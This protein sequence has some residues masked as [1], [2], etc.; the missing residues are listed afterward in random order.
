MHQQG[1]QDM[2]A[3]PVEAEARGQVFCCRSIYQGV[4]QLFQS[5]MCNEKTGV[6]FTSQVEDSSLAHSLQ[7]YTCMTLAQVQV[8]PCF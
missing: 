1:G 3:V 7:L 4:R 8:H 5:C 2:D 6:I